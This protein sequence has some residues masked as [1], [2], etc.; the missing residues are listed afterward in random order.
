MPAV[1]GAIA[2][3]RKKQIKRKKE[4]S[5][6]VERKRSKSPGPNRIKTSPSKRTTEVT[7]SSNQLANTKD[8]DINDDSK[9]GKLRKKWRWLRQFSGKLVT[10]YYVQM[11]VIFLI[12][13]NAIFMGIGT[14]DFIMDDPDMES[15]FERIDKAFLIIFTI[16][17][18]FQIIYNGVRIFLDGWLFFDF[19]VVM[20]SWASDFMDGA[21][22]QVMRAFRIFRAFRLVTR[23][24]TMKGLVTA[25]ID[26]LPNM[27]A[28]IFLLAIIDY[29]FAVMFTSLYKRLDEK[30][31]DE[32]M[33]HYFSTLT[34][35]LFTL[36][37]LM[38][39]DGWSDICRE[40]MEFQPLAWI[41]FVTFIVITGFVAMNLVIAVICDA[42]SHL[43]EHD[44]EEEG[45]GTR[46]PTNISERGDTLE[47]E[48]HSSCR[49][50]DEQMEVMQ[51]DLEK[52]KT[53]QDNMTRMLQSLTNEVQQMKSS[54][55]SIISKSSR[56]ESFDT[57]DT[58]IHDP[59][60]Y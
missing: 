53:N 1:A 50:L 38:T 11:S 17:L 45:N 13:L 22:L 48:S 34:E 47:I 42:V 21:N 49:H 26:T 12:V 16:E 58:Q 29:I 18:G 20:I 39:F 10:N 28:V 36:F 19:A 6:T 41:P 3:A 40:I 44:E 51:S 5:E 46:P 24:K 33:N 59:L 37:Q 56:S 4:R 30:E 55:R 25:L 57:A 23:V 2:A 43:E 54:D 15:L 52:L 31:F 8:N 9:L 32:E 27:S 14:F 60:F 7:E 35:S